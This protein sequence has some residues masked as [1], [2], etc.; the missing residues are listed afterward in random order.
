MYNKAFDL[1]TMD[2]S[3]LITGGS[4]LI[5]RYLTS[6]LLTQG[7]SV[8]HLSR[9]PAQFGRVRV[10]RWDP[11][12]KILDPEILNGVSYIVHLSGANIGEKRW[13]A[14]RKKEI[15]SS[16]VDSLKLLHEVILAKRIRLKALISASASGIYGSICSDRI[17]SEEEDAADDFLG[18]TCR[19]WEEAA[20]LFRDCSDRVVKI[21]TGVVLEKNDSAL[22]R[23]LV[24][25][26]AGIFPVLGGGKQYMPWIHIRDLVKIYAK[27]LGN[28]QM[29]GPYNAVSPHHVTHR[30]FMSA[31][32]KAMNKPFFNPPVP[33][34]ILRAILGEMSDV[35]LKGSRISSDKIINAGYLFEF[36]NLHDALTD[37]L[38]A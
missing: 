28:A 13:S 15:I 38:K 33:G 36:D 34:F 16:R 37:A 29:D 7:Y 1:K 8:S 18:K 4:G 24:P 21:R 19:L 3:V 10:H 14:K 12:K 27:A 9:G 6:E 25:A 5:G 30:E 35:I 2:E 17:F 32:A 23:L 31:L 11:V 26:R 20:G 22:S